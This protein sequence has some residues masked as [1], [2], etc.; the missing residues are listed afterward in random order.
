MSAADFISESIARGARNGLQSLTGTARIVFL[1]SEVEVYCCRDGIDSVVDLIERK[2]LTGASEAFAA[3][4]AD[5]IA[6]GF[7]KI[8]SMLPDRDET[9][10]DRVNALVTDHEGWSYD[11]IKRYVER[12]EPSGT[13]NSG[14]LTLPFGS[15]LKP[16]I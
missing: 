16:L 6:E 15:D 8:E 3:I 4:E 12:A 9:L 1:I 5:A 2:G 11:S 7:R 10:L 13:T 14:E